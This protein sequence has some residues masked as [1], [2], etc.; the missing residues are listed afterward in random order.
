MFERTRLSASPLVIALKIVI[1]ASLGVLA[2][3]VYKSIAIGENA[4]NTA[5]CGCV[6]QAVCVWL[7]GSSAVLGL[8]TVGLSLT[9]SRRRRR[10]EQRGAS[11]ERPRT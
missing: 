3:A 6:D 10:D 2:W 11:G 7:F 8:A 1:L 5:T 9:L 4:S